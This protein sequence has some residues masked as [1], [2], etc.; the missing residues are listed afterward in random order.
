MSH[1]LRY[2]DPAIALRT[3]FTDEQD[4]ARSTCDCQ[5]DMPIRFV[6]E[7]CAPGRPAAIC[8]VRPM[9]RIARARIMVMWTLVDPRIASW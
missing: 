2:D 5:P 8:S 9:T 4:P 1:K 7:I 6:E 3:F